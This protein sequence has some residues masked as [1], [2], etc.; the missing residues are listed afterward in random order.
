[1]EG[2]VWVSSRCSDRLPCLLISD[3][4]RS[5]KSAQ[6]APCCL[7]SSE[8]PDPAGELSPYRGGRGIAQGRGV[9]QGRGVASQGRGFGAG[10]GAHKTP[11]SSRA[12]HSTG[13]ELPVEQTNSL[14][15]ELGDAERTRLPGAHGASRVCPQVQ[16]R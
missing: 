3:F 8:D 10:R 9:T 15:L 2:T 5:L 14:S 6:P 12:W 7:C 1:M 11:A 16:R 13:P 4:A